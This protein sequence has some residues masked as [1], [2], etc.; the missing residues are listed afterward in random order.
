MRETDKTSVVCVLFLGLGGCFRG[1]RGA[2][3]QPEFN[4]AL[5]APAHRHGTEYGVYLGG[6]IYPDPIS[7]GKSFFY[8]R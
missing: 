4:A 6:F 8:V 7:T 2:K 5:N 1:F 3:L